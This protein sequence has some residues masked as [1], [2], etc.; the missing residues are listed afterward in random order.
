LIVTHQCGIIIDIR[1][2]ILWREGAA[3]KARTLGTNIFRRRI[4][5]EFSGILARDEVDR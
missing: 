4:H 5:L 3:G 1:N 2:V